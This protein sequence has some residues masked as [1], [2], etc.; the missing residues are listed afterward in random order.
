MGP[1]GRSKCNLMSDSSADVELAAT[2]ESGLDAA[3]AGD[4]EALSESTVAQN[5]GKII[6][7]RTHIDESPARVLLLCWFEYSKVFGADYSPRI[8]QDGMGKSDLIT[9]AKQFYLES[10]LASVRVIVLRRTVI[11]RLY[12]PAMDC[13]NL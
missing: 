1:A 6:P 11:C 5:A 3:F 10:D 9:Q 13:A 12:M 8:L 4:G 2:V 7:A